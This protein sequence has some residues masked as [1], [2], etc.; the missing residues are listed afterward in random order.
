MEHEILLNDTRQIRKP[1]TVPY[2][3]SKEM[4]T[5]VENML[6]RGVIRESQ[7]P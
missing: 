4:Q 3:L 6:D 5:Q 1:N 7:S 2:A